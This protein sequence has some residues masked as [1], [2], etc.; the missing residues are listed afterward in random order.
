K[1][2]RRRRR[3]DPNQARGRACSWF[4]LAFGFWKISLVATGL[5]FALSFVLGIVE[6]QAR[7]VGGPRREGPPA[8]FMAACLLA[9]GG[10]LFSGLISLVAVVSAVR[11]QVKVWVG[12]DR[13]RVK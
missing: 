13:N 8:E 12:R 3:L 7:G 1:R 10:F 2:A 4:T 9:F 6:A 11:N 5:M